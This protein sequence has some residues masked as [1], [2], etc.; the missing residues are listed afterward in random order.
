MFMASRPLMRA[1]ALYAA[2]LTLRRHRAGDAVTAR[3]DDR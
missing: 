2:L 3:G 1:T